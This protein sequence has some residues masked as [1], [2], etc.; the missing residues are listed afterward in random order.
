MRKG[1]PRH[2]LAKPEDIADTVIMVGDP[3]RA[4]RLASLLG[5]ARLVNENRGF[6]T[7]TGF[8]ENTKVTVATHGIGGPSASLVIEE[9]YDLGA[10]TIVRLGTCGGLKTEIKVGT[11]VIPFGALTLSRNSL[12]MYTNDFCPAAV[13]HPRLQLAM[14]EY[15]RR[16]NIEVREGLVLSSDSFYAEDGYLDMAK[17]L[18]AIAVEMECAALFTLS[19]IKGFKSGAVLIVLNNLESGEGLSK[20]ELWRLEEKIFRLIIKALTKAQLL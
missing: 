4:A 1:K 18:G 13:P 2:I 19:H 7:Y 8:A 6:L 20:E 15:I 12:G 9:L 16:E 3:G 5:E 14:A 10:K 11:V 17:E